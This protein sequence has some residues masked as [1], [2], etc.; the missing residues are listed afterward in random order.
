[1]NNNPNIL[2]VEAGAQ[3]APC[4]AILARQP[5]VGRILLGSHK[6]A[7]AESVRVRLDSE[8]VAA[9]GFDARDPAAIA[10]SVKESLGTV[11]VVIDLTPSFISVHVMEA[12]LALNAHYVNTAACPEHLAQ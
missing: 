8:K 12:T 7:D 4:A 5:G 11:D 9:V 10:R 6:L 2:I 3:G 1:M